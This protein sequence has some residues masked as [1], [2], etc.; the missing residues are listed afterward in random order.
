MK[1]ANRNFEQVEDGPDEQGNYYSR[2]A[3]LSDSIPPPF[4]NEQAARAANFGAHPPDLTYVVYAKR[5]GFN[6]LFA[7]LTGWM[8]APAGVPLQQGQHFNPYFPGG[9]TGMTPVR[10]PFCFLLVFTPPIRSQ[11]LHNDILEYEDG[12]EATESQMAKDV[13]E[14][15]AW[16]AAPEHDA[17]QIMLLKGLGVFAVLIVALLDMYKRNFSHIRSCR[18]AHV[19]KTTR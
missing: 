19:P 12:T 10:S 18:I 15:L 11:I 8:Q 6:Y 17:R 2:P 5:N 9:V 7:Y 14:F 13:V 4:P 3:R 1:H 16:T